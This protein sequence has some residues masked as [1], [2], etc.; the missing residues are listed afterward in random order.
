MGQI[1]ARSLSSLASFAFVV[2]LM[3]VS[4]YAQAE[5]F[6]CPK[7]RASPGA[8]GYQLRGNDRRCEGFYQ[9]PVGAEDIELLSLTAGPVSYNLDL[10][11]TVKLTVP[12]IQPLNALVMKVQARAIPIGTYYRMDAVIPSATTMSWQTTDVLRPAKLSADVVGVL[13]WVEHGPNRV[14]VPI[15]VSSKGSTEKPTIVAIVR[16][17]IDLDRL[18]WRTWIESESQQT[19]G[20][21]NFTD[22]SRIIRAGDPVRLE[23]NLATA[24]SIVEI[25]AKPKGSDQWTLV[26]YRLFAP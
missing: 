9:S 18:Q 21:R 22:G 13:G 12:N 8:A 3:T 1:L 7:L 11:Q 17:S 15:S 23:L 10:D 19:A 24:F 4:W 2:G 26:R 16:P 25:S 14:F 5:E 20:W 6:A